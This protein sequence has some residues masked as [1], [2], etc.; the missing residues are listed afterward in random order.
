MDGFEGLCLIE[1]E[2][3]CSDEKEKKIVE[4]VYIPL[5]REPFG[6]LYDPPSQVSPQIR[7]NFSTSKVMYHFVRK[8]YQA[9][10]NLS[11][12]FLSDPENSKCNKPLLCQFHDV[13]CRS[14][15]E[16]D[17]AKKALSHCQ[18]LVESCGHNDS[19]VWM[20]S[21][22]LHFLLGRIKTAFLH[23]ER[24]V[25]MRNTHSN[26]WL[27]YASTL[28]YFHQSCS[29]KISDISEKLQSCQIHERF[30]KSWVKIFKMDIGNC[31]LYKDHIYFFIISSLTNAVRLAHTTYDQHNSKTYSDFSTAWTFEVSEIL[32]GILNSAPN[33]F[34]SA[35]DKNYNVIHYQNWED[36]MWEQVD[37]LDSFLKCNLPTKNDVRDLSISSI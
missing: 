33:N 28:A 32:K 35:L 2:E 12:S 26:L 18:F 29:D 15:L 6:F 9:A 7:C 19:D 1:D 8:E 3:D 24:C 4:E 31:T 30:H 11:I 10:I 13:L 23:L 27:L 21:A 16:L 22:V 5:K 25:G 17:Q 20:S 14:Y 34:S 36:V 37:F